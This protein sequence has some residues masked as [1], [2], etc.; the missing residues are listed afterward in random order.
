MIT[1]DGIFDFENQR[2]VAPNSGTWGDLTTWADWTSWTTDT[3]DYLYWLL[4]PVDLG[5]VKEF[6]LTITTNANGLVDYYI[7]TSDTGAFSG[8]ETE[9]EILA[10]DTGIPA[11]NTRYYQV[12]LGVEKLAAPQEITGIEVRLVQTKNKF[13]IDNL[14]T[15]TIND[16]STEGYVVP[17]NRTVGTITNVQI[18]P[19]EVTP[20][21]LDVYVTDYPTSSIVIPHVT[22]KTSGSISFALY[23]LDN[24]PRDAIVDIL[25]EYLPEMYMDGRNL[26]VR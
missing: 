16:G 22:N 25:V 2:V 13:S 9:T 7:Y 4:E 8:E 20:F 23:G 3:N 14:D 17:F 11:F 18:T 12:G 19:R 21:Q 24:K 1:P 10:E 15:T 5:E 26:R 6:C